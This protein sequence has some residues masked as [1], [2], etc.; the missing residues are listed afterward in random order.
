[1][2][3]SNMK[4]SNNPA[5]NEVLIKQHL[6]SAER[7]RVFLLAESLDLRSTKYRDSRETAEMIVTLTAEIPASFADPLLMFK[8]ALSRYLETL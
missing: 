7:W 1:M 6:R 5:K 8:A 2:I 3:W 4:M